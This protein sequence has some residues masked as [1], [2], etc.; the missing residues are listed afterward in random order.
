MKRQRLAEWTNEL[1]RRPKL[2]AAVHF[3]H[4]QASSKDTREE[5]A[6]PSRAATTVGEA[7]ESDWW[8]RMGPVVADV[9][10]TYNLITWEMAT[11]PVGGHYIDQTGQQ[12]RIGPYGT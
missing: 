9:P 11:M 6:T 1:N 7:M 4:V 10:V 12:V 2:K 8:C 3:N 5:Q